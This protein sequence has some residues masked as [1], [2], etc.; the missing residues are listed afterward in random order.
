MDRKK[1]EKKF[2]NLSK[3]MDEKKSV[4]PIQGVR[5]SEKDDMP[6]KKKET[7]EVRSDL[8]HRIRTLQRGY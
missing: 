1:I 6:I 2:P 5:T 4:V 3:E 7:Q 8:F